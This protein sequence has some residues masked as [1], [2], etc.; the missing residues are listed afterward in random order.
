MTIPTQDF[1]FVT[2][3][4]GPVSNAA[5]TQH[6]CGAITQRLSVAKCDAQLTVQRGNSTTNAAGVL[7]QATITPRFLPD[8]LR[9]SAS[10]ANLG[11]YRSS[12]DRFARDNRDSESKSWFQSIKFP[13]SEDLFESSTL[14]VTSTAEIVFR[15]SRKEVLSKF[16]GK[17]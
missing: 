11:V 12:H 10:E 3:E 16:S 1:L 14:A 2:A 17:S 8:E 15:G 13:N 4:H 9:A 7:C 5:V 6:I